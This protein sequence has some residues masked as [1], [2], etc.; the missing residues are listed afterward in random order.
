MVLAATGLTGAVYLR[1]AARL[2]GNEAKRHARELARS[3]AT[4]AAVD[5]ANDNRD[6]LLRTAHTLVPEGEL[7][8]IVFTDSMG[9]VLAAYQKGPGRLEPMMRGDDARTI[10]VDPLDRPTLVTRGD[11]G[12]HVDVV[13]PVTGPSTAPGTGRPRPVVGYVR[14][15]LGLE[16][17]EARLAGMVR[18]VIALAGGIAILM[19]PLG[20]FVV[21]GV[22][23]P[24]DRLSAAARRLAAG[25]RNTVVDIKGRDEIGELGRAFNTMATDLAEA[26][27]QLVGV[28]ARLEERVEERTNAL[29]SANDQLRR[30][31]AEKDDFVRAVSHDLSA[32]LRNAAGMAARLR[33]EQATRLT[34]Q[35]A[36]RLDRIDHN[37][38][39][40]MELIDEL[41]ELS[42]IQTITTTPTEIDLHAEVTTVAKELEHDLD[43]KGLSITI[44]Q[45]LPTIYCER[46]L[47]R[48][49]FQNLIDNAIK[50]TDPCRTDRPQSKRIVISHD[51]DAEFH[52]IRIA[53]NG[54]GV[55]PEDRERIFH[56]FR[57][58][59][60]AFARDVPGA[61]VGL[62][63]CKSIVQRLGGR[64][65]VEANPDGGSVFCFSLSRASVSRPDCPG[66]PPSLDPCEREA[67][68]ACGGVQ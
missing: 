38:E 3:L 17:V 43:Q 18:Q 29:A 1:M 46:R 9:S 55:R 21:R 50:Y 68:A 12:S 39:R 52:H 36:Q 45:R 67:G 57:R 16:P 22:A 62:A 47:V 26:H 51:G 44:E 56:V 37:L 34:P 6:S 30:E 7:V 4:A 19:V 28:N 66:G 60:S 24:I 42:Q 2:A 25:E 27:N 15:G 13:Y 23:R 59:S 14:V 53:D 58:A 35:A 61:G 54:I 10:S 33:D 11:A 41:L 65:W 63:C 5:V 31:I 20:Y 8:Y 48:P 64:I 32:P 49:L 40:G